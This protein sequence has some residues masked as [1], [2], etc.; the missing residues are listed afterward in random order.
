M[1]L[2]LD[3]YINI[4]DPGQEVY[5]VPEVLSKT[6]DGIEFI[7]VIESLTKPSLHWVRKDA[8]KKN[9]KIIWNFK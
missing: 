1:K 4:L 2:A 8:Y 6:V 5:L 9:G 7:P 3:K